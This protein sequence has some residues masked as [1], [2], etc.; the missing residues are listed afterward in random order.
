MRAAGTA[1]PWIRG[2]RDLFTLSGNP[3]VIRRPRGQPVMMV[4]E[5]TLILPL[6]IWQSP[7]NCSERDLDRALDEMAQ[8]LQ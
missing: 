2:I 1:R 3:C 8:Y 4:T 6:R 5:I 7:D